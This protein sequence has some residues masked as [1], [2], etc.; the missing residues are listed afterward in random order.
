[1]KSSVPAKA[2]AL[3]AL[4]CVT[5]LFTLAPFAMAA[6]SPLAQAI[7][8]LDSDTRQERVV[9]LSDLGINEPIL[10]DSTDARRELF[11]PVPSGVPLLD[12]TLDVDA[13]YLNGEKGRN[14]LLLSLDGYP[15]RAEGLSADEGDASAS[16]GV[17]KAPRDSGSVRL[18]VA[19]S[20]VVDRELC[21]DERVIGNILRI[22]PD[23]RLR[24]AYDA[25][26]LH[27]VGA[28]WNALPGEPGLL[29]APGT[30]TKASYDAAW[31][32]GVELERTGRQVRILPLPEVGDSLDLSG[33]K[34]A[35][36]LRK[37]PA[38]ARLSDKQRYTLS[39]PADIG[40]LL[41]LGQTKNLSFD[42]AVA[43]P[44]LTQAVNRAL[45]A[46]HNEVQGFDA[47]AADALQQ[48][49]ARHATA[50]LN[51]ARPGNVRLGLLGSRP[52][53]MVEPERVTQ[54]IGLL[55]EAWNKLARNRELT[56]SEARA[57]H[58]E[59]DRIALSRLG[60]EPGSLDVLARTDWSAT[61]PIG[62]VAGNGRTP[63]KAVVDVAA[64]PGASDTAP[65]AAIF[66]ND[67]LIGARQLDATGQRERIEARIPPYALAAR[68]TL[69]VQFQR[70]PVSNQCRETPQPYPVSV[71]PSTHLA[72]EQ[73]TLGADFS[74]VAAR[75][76]VDTQLWLAQAA[77]DHP[78]DSLPQLIRVASATGVSPLRA[79]LNVSNGN[80]SAASPSGAFLAFDVP[81]KGS[82]GSVTVDAS[83]HLLIGGEPQPLVDLQSLDRMAALQVVQ[84]GGQTGVSYHTLGAHPP[85]FDRPLV[86]QRGNVSLLA[87]SGALVTYDGRNASGG[88][89]LDHD[90]QDPTGLD[91]WRKPSLLWL[92]PAGFVLILLLIL[93]GRVARSRRR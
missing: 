38:F 49:R 12:A 50:A 59:D 5:G 13:S 82:D 89:W 8:Q 14:T 4:A 91:A 73:Q 65:V 21:Q 20:S 51:P 10:L 62:S 63:V 31:R 75:F 18:G 36:E 28:A 24:Y 23:T 48:W 83:G 15:V 7:A 86:L 92:I 77:L 6:D 56:I 84:A 70:Q 88:E 37:I 93:A 34:I 81:V 54:A 44:A 39:N 58:T 71:L 25:R 29:V 30:L 17:D 33:L 42:V 67:Y 41:L 90:D 87:D 45:D 55:G 32:L 80:D 16:L 46:L 61:F 64:A 35:P 69:R 40:A 53:L 85:R 3:R 79:G 76:A 26:D 2:G 22:Q 47:Q 11:L 74:G 57:P 78:G 68:N 1:M 72:L 19:W 27:D 66:F 9:Q 60:G 52:V 43:D